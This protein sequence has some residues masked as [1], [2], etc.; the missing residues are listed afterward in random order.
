MSQ[1][2]PEN[3]VDAVSQKMLTNFTEVNKVDVL[4]TQMFRDGSMTTVEFHQ[5][6]LHMLYIKKLKE[7]SARVTEE[8]LHLSNQKKK[9]VS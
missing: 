2:I 1:D 3:N 6:I 7:S 5:Q 8:F 4:N 9:K